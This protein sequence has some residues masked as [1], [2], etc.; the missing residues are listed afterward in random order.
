[1]TDIKASSIEKEASADQPKQL[2]LFLDLDGFEGPIDLLLQLAR[3]QKVDLRK[4]AILPLAEQYLIFVNTVRELDLEIAADYLVM[5]AWL[6][7]LKSRLLLPREKTAEGELSGEE[8]AARLQ[9]QLQRLDAMRRVCAQ[10]MTRKRLGLDIFPRGAPETVRTVRE[11][12]WTADIYDLI[13]AYADQRRR[14]IKS[15]HVVK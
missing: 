13:K 4:I 6:A 5:A 2:S 11:T 3:D 15:V 9:F 14:T 8:L 1:M 10:L 7:F 12:T